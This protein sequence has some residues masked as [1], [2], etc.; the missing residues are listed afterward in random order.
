MTAKALQELAHDEYVRERSGDSRRWLPRPFR[1]YQRS[2]LRDDVV[3]GLTVAALVVPLG[4]AFAQL[5]GLPPVYG[6]YTSIVPVVAFALVASTPQSIVGAEAALS[7]VVA[8]AI[9]PSVAAGHDPVKAASALALM[10]GVVSLVGAALHAGRLSQVVSRTV[11]IGYLAGV[12]LSVSIGQLPRLVGADAFEHD[13]LLPQLTELPTVFS[14]AGAASTIIGVVTVA[15]VLLGRRFASR[16]PAA[17]L[18]LVVT[19]AAVAALG[20]GGDVSLIGSLPDDL[21]GLVIPNLHV[22]DLLGMLPAALAIALIGFADTT[23]VSQGFAARNGYHVDSSRDLAALGAADVAS[24]AFGGLPLSASSARTAA[25]EASGAHSQMAGIASAG[26]VAVALL[27]GADLVGRI[28]QPALAGIIIAVMVSLVDVEALR[29][30]H[31]GRRSELVVCLVAFGGVAMLGVLQGVAVAIAMSVGA[32]VLRAARPHDAFL[33]TEP[34][35]TKLVPL[36]ERAAA[37][38]VPGVVVYR[39]DAPLFFGN[40]DQLRDRLLTSVRKPSDVPLRHVVVAASAITDIDYTAMQVLDE[41]ALQLQALDI[42]LT[43]AGIN[44]ELAAQLARTARGGRVRY[45]TTSPEQVL[46]SA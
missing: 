3:A 8:A 4:L 11:F 22:D 38:P 25:A 42:D 18:M 32:I 21:P 31:A 12:A 40:A 23:L 16:L 6:L 2:W 46:A 39:M 10:I 34:G 15:G 28:P 33:G 35:S 44:H 41:L 14:A 5:A 30:L 20:M 43:V 27:A 29:T 36:D 7:G 19:G 24:G 17:L 26:A 13:S 1:G 9:A 45:T 37:R